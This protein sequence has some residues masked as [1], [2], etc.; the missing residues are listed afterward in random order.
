MFSIDSMSQIP[1]YE[2]LINQIER[3][4]LIGALKGGD[5]MPSVRGLSVELSVNP[6]TIQKSYSELSAR[7]VLFAVPGKGLFVSDNAKEI[8][9][10]RRREH[11]DEF[12]KLVAELK[13]AGIKPQELK[14][15]IDEEV[16]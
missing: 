6:N 7:G 8:I 9:G 5:N 3:F 10:N 1:V 12:K 14:N 13:L 2:Q 11:L 16:L 4:I 15:I